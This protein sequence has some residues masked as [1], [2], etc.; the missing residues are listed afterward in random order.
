MEQLINWMFGLRI[1]ISFFMISFCIGGTKGLHKSKRISFFHRHHD[2]LVSLYSNNQI[3]NSTQLIGG[4]HL[5]NVTVQLVAFGH[6]FV[7]DLQLNKNLFSK[8]YVEKTFHS[9]GRNSESSHILPENKENCYYHGRLRFQSGSDSAL[10]TCNGIRGYV[11]DKY[12]TYHIEPIDGKI[13]RVYRNKDQRQLPFKCGTEGHDPRLQYRKAIIGRHK[14]SVD[15]PYDS[16]SNTRYVE[17]YL[18]N[19]YRTYERHGKNIDMVIKRSQDIANIVSSLYRQLNIYVALVGVEVWDGG[20]HV[21]VTTSADKTMENFLR[22]RRERINP[23]HHNDNAQLITGVFF[24]H[25]VVGKA[26]K[27][28]I[29][30]HQFSGGVNMDYGGLV[31][32]VATTVAHEMGHNFGMEHDNDTMCECRDDK[33]I[34]AATS[35]QISP[36]RWSSC[37]QNALAEAFDLGMDYCLRNLPTTI[38]DGPICGN[39]LKEDGEDCD[40]GLPHDC[41]NRCCNATSCRM[42]AAAQCATGRC[43]DF[44]SCKPKGSSTLCR[45]PVSECDLGEFC[46]GISE[47]CPEDVFTQNGIECKQGQSYCYNGQCKTHTDQCKLLW[48]ESG[49]VSDPICFQ[50]LN[51][52]GNNDGNCGYNWT[53]DKY[54]RCEKENVMC[55]LL[56]C[57]HL[58]E[59]LMFWRDNLAI[60]MR[61]SFLSRGNKQYVCRSAMLDVGLDMPDPG[62]VPD[63]SKCEHDKVCINQQCVPIAKLRVEQCSD[64]CHGKGRCNSRGNCHCDTGYAPPYCDRP[65]Y[66]GSID[67]GPA[68]DEYAKKDL[69]IALLVMFLLVIPLIVLLV[70]AFF[71][72]HKLAKWWEFMPSFTYRVRGKPAKFK[73]P[74]ESNSSVGKSRKELLPRNSD[75][76]VSFTHTTDVHPKPKVWS[77]VNTA[78]HHPAPPAPHH[79]APAAPRCPAPAAPPERP[80]APKR[81]PSLLK[82]ASAAETKGTSKKVKLTLPIQET[83]SPPSPTQ[84]Q[85]KSSQFVTS[86]SGKQEP[87]K[88][89]LESHIP[90]PIVKRESFRGSEISEPVLV[91]TTNRNSLVLADGNV[92]IIGPEARLVTRGPSHKGQ[93]S[94]TVKRSQSD[95]PVARQEPQRPADVPPPPGSAKVKKSASARSPPPKNNP[96]A[97]SAP[98][99]NNTKV[100]PSGFRPRPIPP[101]PTEEEDDSQPIY[102]N[103]ASDMSDLLTAIDGALKDS[104]NLYNNISSTGNIQIPIQETAPP[105]PPRPSSTKQTSQHTNPS[106]VPVNKAVTPVTKPISTPKPPSSALESKLNNV[107][108]IP[109]PHTSVPRQSLDNASKTPLSAPDKKIKSDVTSDNSDKLKGAVSDELRNKILSRSGSS[110]TPPSG[111]TGLDVHPPVTKSGSNAA[112]LSVVSKDW[113]SAGEPGPNRPA[114]STVKNTL[115]AAK[116]GTGPTNAN[117]PK[118][119]SGVSNSA[120]KSGTGP[121]NSVSTTGPKTGPNT[122]SSVLPGSGRVNPKVAAT[123]KAPNEAAKSNVSSIAAK[124]GSSKQDESKPTGHRALGQSDDN[125]KKV[126]IK[127]VSDAEKPTVLI[128]KVKP[129]SA[130]SEVNEKPVIRVQSMNTNSP[131]PSLPPKPDQGSANAPDSKSNAQPKRVQS[132]RI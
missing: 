124:F 55:G 37:S 64:N 110:A 122:A 85:K 78:S 53:T 104:S 95:R 15:V 28:P 82:S 115:G 49:R 129:G 118:T 63:G 128:R 7:V 62:F 112:S 68:S 20:D 44:D 126:P 81:P 72:R 59:K 34:M 98:T 41:G 130:R 12:D 3:V 50:Q 43:C 9:H 10:S 97:T 35:G 14:R 8:S 127:K 32:L 19:D 111:T 29:C 26:I 121:A 96:A 100:N 61:A 1:I 16:N 51:M 57:V 99:T 83:G 113:A 88:N 94:I 125:A 56:H 58:N 48:G 119:G 54:K 80:A 30:T 120:A 11:T 77:S 89:M 123:D 105:A 79:P 46:D 92:D 75:N 132:F 17:L 107:N 108:V 117:M 47:S 90:N 65:G 73:S 87:S 36:R 6:Q 131:R 60:D 93:G 69:L 91:C 71:K 106:S 67:S 21:S 5:E 76:T 4:Q 102:T 40:C 74:P 109:A 13:H 84:K 33:C 24:E 27:G 52:N 18:V 101:I 2:C 70:I 114:R 45:A 66:G 103:E 31:T 23:Y 42:F 116:S 86:V 22:Y 39:G 38:Y 25:G